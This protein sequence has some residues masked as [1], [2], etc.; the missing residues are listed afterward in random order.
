MKT[1][2]QFITT[3][4]GEELALLPKADY[5]KMLEVVEDYEDIKAARKFRVKLR[6]GEEELIP[7]EYVNRMV[8]GENKIKVWRAFRG[9]TI[10]ALADAAGISAAYLWQ[11]E[12]GT[13]EGSL[14]AL[15][16][17][18]EVLNVT[19]DDLALKE[20]R[21]N[22]ALYL[23]GPEVRK[24]YGI[25]AQTIIKWT[26]DEKL[27]FPNPIKIRGRNFWKPEEL[28]AFDEKNRK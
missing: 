14:D 3:P 2:V 6:S 19:I 26:K 9:M 15:T 17:L 25:S 20:M 24:R 11:L 23:N 4:L 1:Q 18:A 5:E 10:K 16:K 27:G 8:E 7:A 22:R 21:K 28:E 12:G 13:R